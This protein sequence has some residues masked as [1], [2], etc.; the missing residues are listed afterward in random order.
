MTGKTIYPALI[1]AYSEVEVAQHKS[2]SAHWNKHVRPER[3]AGLDWKRSKSADQKLRQSGFALRLVAPNSGI[4]K[5]KSAI[6]TTSD[7]PPANSIV[8]KAVANH[9]RLTAPRNAGREYP[10]SPM[11]AVAL[12]RQ[13]CYDANWYRDAWRAYQKDPRTPRP[14]TNVALEILSNAIQNN[15]LFILD[16][17]DEQ[18]ALRADR[19]AVEFDLIYPTA[20]FRSRIPKN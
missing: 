12:A 19:F 1:D 2:E 9:V 16:A 20:G 14:E 10:R 18:Y 8:R 3:D 4:L 13:T 15:E 5:G 11:G 6:V 7:T 17:P